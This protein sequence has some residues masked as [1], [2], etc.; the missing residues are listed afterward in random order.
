MITYFLGILLLLIALRKF[1]RKP[2]SPPGP[3]G[4]PILGYLPWLDIKKPFETLT[5]LSKTYGPVFSVDF[6]SVKCVVV[7]DNKI[8]KELF[9]KDQLTGC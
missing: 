1:L 5:K 2:S 6:G 8:M 9:S 4:I 7:T 3:M